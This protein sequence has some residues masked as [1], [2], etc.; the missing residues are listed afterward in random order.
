ML[1]NAMNKPLLYRPE[2]DGLRA[3]AIL[4][5]LGFHFRPTWIPGGFWGVDI[6]FVISGYL[7]SGVISCSLAR[8]D[9]SFINFFNSRVRRLFPSLIAV[10][11]CSYLTG[12]FILF[13][14][15]LRS[16]NKHI[17]FSALFSENFVLQ[18]ESGYFDAAIDSKPLMHLW[19]LAIECQ[20]YLIFPFLLS[21]VAFFNKRKQIS[22][23]VALSVVSFFVGQYSIYSHSEKSFFDS[24][25]RFWEFLFGC[26][27]YLC[28]SKNGKVIRIE[29][30][31]LSEVLSFFC[32]ALVFFSYFFIDSEKAAPGAWTIVP[33]VGAM[34]LI[35][36]S[37]QNLRF[38]SFLKIRIFVEIGLISYALYLWHWPIFVFLKIVESNYNMSKIINLSLVATF[39]LAWF[40]TYYIEAPARRYCQGAKVYI[41]HLLL[42]CLVA[43]S[44]GLMITN[45]NLSSGD[46]K[47]GFVSYFDN[48]PPEKK[49]F[50]MAEINKL[51][52]SDCDF[53]TDKSTES[54][55]NIGDISPSCYS[56]VTGG[57]FLWGDSHA[58]QLRHGIDKYLGPT[59]PIY[60]IATS[61]CLP[62]VNFDTDSNLCNLSNKFALDKIATI[63]PVVVIIAQVSGH[64]TKNDYRDIAVKLKRLGVQHVVIVGPV[65]QWPSYLYKLVARKLWYSEENRTNSGLSSVPFKSD[66]D[67]ENRYGDGRYLTYFSAIRVF[68]DSNGCLMFIGDRRPENLVTYDYGH[69][70]P[71][72]SEYL[73]RSLVPVLSQLIYSDQSAKY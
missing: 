28:Q 52:R 20:F 15:E 48:S 33:V 21:L 68:C 54:I 49:Y 41:L 39:F 2:L 69:L 10:L 64:D 63:K 12:V 44:T 65:P 47:I 26:G 1:F 6:F 13:P 66:I 11:V 8:G 60:Q 51:Y 5:V 24:I 40:T 70:T 37:N 38:L 50:Q 56:G 18:Q 27:V 32:L 58:Q 25:P 17:V 19:S 45:A 67:L 53:Y 71:I 61:G 42:F 43:I 55:K 9:F 73:A 72:A 7:I 3:M 30:R 34:G 36:L 59:T 16:L 14:D 22:L 31:L 29:N 62:N 57:V 35:F 46:E 4:G 23:V